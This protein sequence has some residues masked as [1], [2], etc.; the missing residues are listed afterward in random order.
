MI[1]LHKNKFETDDPVPKFDISELHQ[2]KK[3]GAPE[4]MKRGAPPS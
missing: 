1:L 3:G 2:I 4:D